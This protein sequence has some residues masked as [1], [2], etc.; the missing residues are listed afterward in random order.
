[1]WRVTTHHA[2]YR[3][4]QYGWDHTDDEEFFAW[5]RANTC[6]IGHDVWIGH[7][8]TVTAGVTIGT[9]ACIGAGAVVTREIP[10]YA[11]AVG[12]PARVIKYRFDD[13]TIEK[14][15]QIAFW[16]WNHDTIRERFRDLLDT[17]SFIEKY[18]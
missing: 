13:P 2:T 6:T 1:V 9:G 7:G 11:I 4:R 14:L 18:G 10:P 3:R 15:L 17:P 12:V 16:E 5:R 8:V